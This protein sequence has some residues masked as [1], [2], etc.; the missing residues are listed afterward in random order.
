MAFRFDAGSFSSVPL[1]LASR[2]RAVLALLVACGAGAVLPATARSSP[3]ARRAV[4]GR[5]V[6]GRPIVAVEVGDPASPRALVVGCIHGNEC[7]GVPIAERLEALSPPR[8][9]DLWIVPDLNPDGNARGTRGNAHGV[10]LNRNFPWHWRPL[11]GSC[12][13]GPRP[14]SEPESRIA[15]R[16]IL[17]LRPRISIWFHQHLDLVDE[18]GGNPSVERSFARLTG[19]PLRRLA[20]YPGS[21]AS[22]ENAALPGTTAFVVELPPGSLSAAAADRFSRAV[23]EVAR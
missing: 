19:L 5:S 3:P 7:A 16:L 20:R 21:V 23:L 22:W 18:S 15:H 9:V 8:G 4:L 6:D 13:S 17:R 10:D 11:S 1:P 2:Q 12:D 14:L